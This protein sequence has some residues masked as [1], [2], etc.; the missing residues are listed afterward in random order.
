M[1][2]PGIV[3]SSPDRAPA[4]GPRHS[5]SERDTP[6]RLGTLVVPVPARR[7]PIRSPD[8]APSSAS[9]GLQPGRRSGRLWPTTKRAWSG[10]GAPDDDVTCTSDRRQVMMSPMWLLSPT[11]ASATVSSSSH[12]NNPKCLTLPAGPSRG[13]DGGGPGRYPAGRRSCT[14]CPVSASKAWARVGTRYSTQNQ[15]PPEPRATRP[16]RSPPR[17]RARRY[18]KSRRPSAPAGQHGGPWRTPGASRGSRSG[19]DVEPEQ[20]RSRRVAALVVPSLGEVH[21]L[22]VGDARTASL[23]LVSAAHAFGFSRATSRDR[24][25]DDLVASGGVKD[26]Q[27]SPVLGRAVDQSASGPVLP[28][29]RPSRPA[30]LSASGRP[31]SVNHTLLH[32]PS[33]PSVLG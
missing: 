20:S 1:D 21:V 10:D 29:R 28:V 7:R 6:V 25:A 26:D 2:P 24:Q 13:T 30:R 23:N 18:A 15:R 14:G 27:V 19:G 8:L 9:A 5:G 33:W 11:C 16:P 31:P 22:G 3:N 32:A 17:S 12:S 4:L